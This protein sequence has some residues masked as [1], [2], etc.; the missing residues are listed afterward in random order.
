MR[1]VQTVYRL[2]KSRK[3]NVQTAK[4]EKSW[5]RYDDGFQDFFRCKAQIFRYLPGSNEAKTLFRD[6]LRLIPF[7]E[8]ACFHPEDFRKGK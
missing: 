2:S 8:V 7:Q 3:R 5:N 6:Y 4:Q 1:K